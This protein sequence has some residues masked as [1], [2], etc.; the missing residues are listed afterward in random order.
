MSHPVNQYS[1]AELRELMMRVDTRGFPADLAN[2]WKVEH[3]RY[4][5]TL[6]R[7]PPA[8]SPAA[9]L[10]D[11]GSSRPWLPFYQVLLGYQNIVL[12]TRY[13]D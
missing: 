11:L 9:T 3:V 13:P 2:L 4:R 6:Q 7:I 1:D 12:N 5:Q 10:L 8:Q